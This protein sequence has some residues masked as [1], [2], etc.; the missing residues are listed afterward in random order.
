MK[1][2]EKGTCF[3]I[4]FDEKQFGFG[5][6]TFATQFLVVNV[7]D[8]LSD[9]EKELETAFG[10]PLI[11]RDW[12]T[13]WVVFMTFKN[14]QF[15]KWKLKRNRIV[16]EILPPK[17]PNVIYAN[18]V[19][20]FETGETGRPATEADRRTLEEVSLTVSTLYNVEIRKCFGLDSQK[21]AS[22]A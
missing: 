18:R 11:K 4:P 8:F 9:D 7:F 15:P 19:F 1:P 22:E 6:V 17:Q 20:N 2:I 12:I 10:K 3:V 21:N 16:P 5:Y 13:D 14:S